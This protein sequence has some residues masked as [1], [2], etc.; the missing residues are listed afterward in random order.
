MS[1]AR[2]G[3]GGGI[4]RAWQD[5][6][7]LVA[8]DAR[9]QVVVAHAAAQPARDFLQDAVARV[10]A[11]DV[12][13]RLE[14]VEVDEQQ[15]AAP[16][17]AARPC[18]PRLEEP[19]RLGPVRQLGQAVVR[20]RPAD[21]L[22]GLAP[23]A[24]VA[25]H[26]VHQPFALVFE[27][28]GGDLD[29]DIGAVP[30]AVDAFERRLLRVAALGEHR[31]QSLRRGR[32]VDLEQ[33]HRQQFGVAV[34]EAFGGHAVRIADVAVFVEEQQHF[35]GVL[36]EELELLQLVALRAQRRVPLLQQGRGTLDRR[37]DLDRLGN[38]HGRNRRRRAPAQRRGGLDQRVDGTGNAPADVTRQQQS[39]AEQH[40][41]RRAQVSH[42]GPQRTG[43]LR[44]RYA[45]NGRIARQRRTC[46]HG[47]VR[48]TVQAG[49]F[50][51][52][53]GLARDDGAQALEREVPD[54]LPGAT[55]ARGDDAF[56]VE[57]GRKPTV[58]Q[59]ALLQ[60]RRQ[61][62]RRN[63][64]RQRMDDL[65][66][67]PDRHVDADDRRTALVDGNVRDPCRLAREH[68]LHRP[69]VVARRHPGRGRAG[70]ADEAAPVAAIDHDL[71]RGRRH[72]HRACRV[73]HKG[74]HV[75][76]RQVA[77]VRQILRHGLGMQEL[78]VGRL[79]NRTRD[80]DRV[81]GVALLFLAVFGKQ[82]DPYPD[83]ARKQADQHQGAEQ[84]GGR[85]GSPHE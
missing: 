71:A 59:S 78:L 64:H 76:G 54:E 69:R 77:G 67:A 62:G 44:T 83:Q 41:H 20:G 35:V 10:V 22:F 28:G 53:L 12:V 48:H 39:Q 45:D 82:E 65:A 8:A 80:L 32:Q 31:L 2:R 42:P 33:G 58:G 74:V 56:A 4:V 79:A 73:L 70:I 9:Q 43:Q 17:H 75:A 68:P 63:E 19:G 52:T 11:I 21:C 50:E 24:D 13:D 23:L 5:H 49:G 27:H 30:A 72:R 38:M 40:R 7:E 84:L 18:Q 81:F 29:R 34:A 47:K 55:V 25:R 66:I 57:H 6:Q 1:S 51:A 46:E 26:H 36:R 16:A 14:A 37:G 85:A 60:Q 15:G 3:L 61:L